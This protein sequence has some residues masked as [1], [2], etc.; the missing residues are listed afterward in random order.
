M[1]ELLVRE[2]QPTFGLETMRIRIDARI[3]VLEDR[4]HGDAGLRLVSVLLVHDNGWKVMRLQ[5]VGN[6][7][8]IY[9]HRDLPFAV[10]ER[11]IARD[12][13]MSCN[14]ACAQTITQLVKILGFEHEWA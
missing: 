12:T 11:F 8:S 9:P 10:V 7:R 13:L 14:L 3:H 5:Q 1:F 2:I 4:S 6:N